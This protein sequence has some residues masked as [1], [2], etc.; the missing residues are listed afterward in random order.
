M[1]GLHEFYRG[2]KKIE[3]ENNQQKNN[4][5]AFNIKVF[6][7]KNEEKKR[8]RVTCA[9]MWVFFLFFL[10]QQYS[11]RSPPPN[12]PMLPKTKIV[13]KGKQLCLRPKLQFYTLHFHIQF[14]D[15][16]KEIKEMTRRS[17]A[18]AKPSAEVNGGM[19]GHGSPQTTPARPAL[20]QRTSSLSSIQVTLAIAFV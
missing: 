7:Y 10:M 3:Y 6:I 20:H 5:K 1:K 11:K 13:R 2:K 17:V 19:E 18:S 15:K 14:I 16:F 4:N 12:P 9:F 8:C